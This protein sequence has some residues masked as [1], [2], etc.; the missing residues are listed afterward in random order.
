MEVES[1]TT[2]TVTVKWKVDKLSQ[3]LGTKEEPKTEGYRLSPSFARDEWRLKVQLW[4]Q[5]M[6]KDLSEASLGIFM[7]AIPLQDDH[8]G[9]V[10]SRTTVWDS[11]TAAWGFRGKLRLS[12]YFDDAA[13]VSEDAFI[14]CCT[15]KF[16][17]PAAA[18]AATNKLLQALTSSLFSSSSGDVIFRFPRDEQQ[19]DI[20]VQSEILKQRCGYFRSMLSSGFIEGSLPP[21]PPSTPKK[22]PNPNLSSWANDDDEL[23][24]LPVDWVDEYGPSMLGESHIQGDPA[25]LS[26]I[27]EVTDFGY[28]TYRAMLY[29]LYTDK[30]TFT[31]PA[32]DFTVA[33]LK[34]DVD[35]GGD[36]ISRRAYL[37]RQA[38]RGDGVVEPAS[39]HAVYR[40]ADKIDLPELKERAKEAI[41]RG[42]TVENVLY[43]LVST[44][45]HQHDE[46]QELCVSFASNHWDE[47]KGTTALKRVIVGANEVEGGPELLQKLLEKGTTA[48]GKGK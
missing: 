13:L 18:T 42:L 39:P 23:Q 44:L 22:S 14:F 32:S 16:S 1:S 20:T 11:E 31:P 45:A 21:T 7:C 43:E 26:G 38:K 34:G 47:I 46:I 3:L 12:A 6:D 41:S 40:L 10:L 28:T 19:R 2:T 27:I 25:P 8:K 15:L 29:Y 5:E 37:L 33:F 17:A 48:A 4:T 35:L 30:I 36:P 24:W 9:D